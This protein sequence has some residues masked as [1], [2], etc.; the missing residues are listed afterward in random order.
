MSIQDYTQK[1]KTFAQSPKGRDVAVIFIVILTG[2]ICFVLGR[3]SID[4]QNGSGVVIVGGANAIGSQLISPNTAIEPQSTVKS[5]FTD[6]IAV[7]NTTQV[8]VGEGLYVSSSRGKKYYP[9]DCPAASGLSKKNLVYYKTA[10]E[11]EKAGKTL[12]TSCN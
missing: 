10:M 8:G 4:P 12:S 5:N 7:Q 2:L 3:L 11:A 6:G 9:V 1:I